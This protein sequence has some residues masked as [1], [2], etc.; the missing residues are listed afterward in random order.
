MEKRI[1]RT[2][3]V[4]E[5]VAILAA[6]CRD[7]NSKALP[8]L[9]AGP[10][11]TPTTRGIEAMAEGAFSYPAVEPEATEAVVL[12]REWPQME[13]PLKMTLLVNDG[14]AVEVITTPSL[15][16]AESAV[17]FSRHEGGI[18]L[19]NP[20]D[21]YGNWLLFIHSGY[22]EQDGSW[23]PLPGEELRFY[24][25]GGRY[26]G[27]LAEYGLPTQDARIASLLGGTVAMEQNGRVSYWQVAAAQRVGH[28]NIADFRADA[29]LVVD[30]LGG[31][32]QIFKEQPGIIE[33]ISLRAGEGD[34]VSGDER[35]SY[36]V[37]VIG[38]AEIK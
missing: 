29:R 27:S 19:V 5:I 9:A 13:L 37:L 1:L 22:A 24:I 20:S 7:W 12:P 38:L 33:V 3:T 31:Q 2:L 34:G 35:W 14:V 11:P 28:D 26:A 8:A 30:K 10:L 32:F 23:L 25:Q 18:S 17:K 6:G 15:Y 16:T 36:E 4:V 21:R